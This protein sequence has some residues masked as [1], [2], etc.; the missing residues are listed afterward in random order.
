M[1]QSTE[2][3]GPRAWFLFRCLDQPYAVRLESVSE[4]IPADR[5][6]RLPLAPPELVGLCAI[7]RDIIPVV[8]LPGGPSR[9]ASS[10]DATSAVLV[11]HAEQGV[12][13]IGISREGVAV[14]EAEPQEDRL[15]PA[16]GH[17]EMPHRTICRCGSVYSVIHPERAWAG[18]RAS[19]VR[20]YSY[21]LNGFTVPS[22]P[23]RQA[24]GA[25]N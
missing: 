25:L 14:V 1:R 8:A 5:L 10:L 17:P 24:A 7:R 18:V 3:N 19:V 23:T 4:I 16:P 12:W 11:L 20:W 13:G 2:R 6:I 21:L 22:E 15:A 9:P